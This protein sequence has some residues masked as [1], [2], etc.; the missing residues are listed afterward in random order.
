MTVSPTGSDALPPLREVIA[1]TANAKRKVNTLLDLNLTRRIAITASDLSQGT[2]V[3]VG[4]GPGGLLV[5]CWRPV[6]RRLLRSNET[7]VA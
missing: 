3:E 4:P 1:N 2:T 5:L 7:S 6:R